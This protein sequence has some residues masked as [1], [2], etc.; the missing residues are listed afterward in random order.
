MKMVF[1]QKMLLLSRDEQVLGQ[2]VGRNN[3]GSRRDEDGIEK[4]VFK[5]IVTWRMQRAFVTIYYNI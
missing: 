5:E 3:R 4:M 1:P 2:A